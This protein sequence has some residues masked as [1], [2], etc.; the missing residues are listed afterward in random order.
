MTASVLDTPFN[1]ATTVM[2]NVKPRDFCCLASSIRIGWVKLQKH[3][4]V[5]SNAIQQQE[6]NFYAIM[7]T[8]VQLLHD[9][10]IRLQ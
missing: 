5:K 9:R 6:L 3:R 10:C 7:E 8:F 4:S 2:D 1:F